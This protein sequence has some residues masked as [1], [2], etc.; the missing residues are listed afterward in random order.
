MNKLVIVL[1][2]GLNQLLK[3]YFDDSQEELVT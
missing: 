3:Y 2:E 1:L